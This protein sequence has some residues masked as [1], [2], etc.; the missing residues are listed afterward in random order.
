MV[1]AVGE[2]DDPGLRCQEGHDPVA[3]AD[4]LVVQ[5]EIG[6]EHDGSAHALTPADGGAG[7][8]RFGYWRRC[9]RVFFSSFLCFFLRIRLRRF[10]TTEGKPDPFRQFR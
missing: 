8:R 6:Q 3:D 9:Q 7:P 5:A 2:I 1:R 4:E 10:L